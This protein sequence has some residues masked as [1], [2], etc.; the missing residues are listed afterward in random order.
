MASMTLGICVTM[1]FEIVK[2]YHAFKAAKDKL[3]A[4]STV[5]ELGAVDS[6]GNFARFLNLDLCYRKSW[7]PYMWHYNPFLVLN[8]S[9]L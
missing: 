7:I 6:T 1:Y 5:A 8:C 9:Q 4:S 2:S 3:S